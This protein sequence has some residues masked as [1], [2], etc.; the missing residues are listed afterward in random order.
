[1]PAF[2][3]HE[4]TQVTRQIVNCLNH[5]DEFHDARL[6]S[7]AMPEI[8]ADRFFHFTAISKYGRT[9]PRKARLALVMVWRRLVQKGGTLAIQKRLRVGAANGF[10]IEVEVVTSNAIQSGHIQF[11]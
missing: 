4:A 3:S 11:A 9:Q 8:R 2:G 7:R 6:V 1:M 5:A 10:Q